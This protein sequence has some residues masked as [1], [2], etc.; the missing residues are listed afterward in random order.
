MSKQRIKTDATTTPDDEGAGGTTVKLVVESVLWVWAL[1]V[2]GYFYYTR[3]FHLL[4]RYAWERV[5]G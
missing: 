3:D 4:L 1:A 2:I 5:I